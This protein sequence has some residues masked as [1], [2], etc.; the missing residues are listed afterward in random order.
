MQYIEPFYEKELKRIKNRWEKTHPERV[1]RFTRQYLEWGFCDEDTWDLAAHLAE[2]IL[3]RLKRFKEIAA[4]KITFPLDDMIEAFEIYK[5]V[6]YN[7]WKLT[8]KKL[9][10]FE[11]GMKAFSEY[12]LALWW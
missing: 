10:K 11:K 6:D 2:I 8:G 12:F 9:E 7:P 3:P 4:I 1:E 5:E